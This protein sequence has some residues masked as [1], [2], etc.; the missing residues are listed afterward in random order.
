MHF[1]GI[2]LTLAEAQAQLTAWT[3][4]SL[5]LAQGKSVMMGDRRIDRSDW[6]MVQKAITFWQAQVSSLTTATAGTSGGSIRVAS[7][8]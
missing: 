2:G 7:W 8:S 1:R 4:A 3:N 5:A 6:D